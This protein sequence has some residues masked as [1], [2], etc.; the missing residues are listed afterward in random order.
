MYRQCKCTLLYAAAAPCDGDGDA[1]KWEV[2]TLQ[3]G[4]VEA[5]P[6]VRRDAGE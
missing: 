3:C 5:S 1:H 4:N 6:A 2:I